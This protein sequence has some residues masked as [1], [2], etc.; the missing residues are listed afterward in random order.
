MSNQALL[1]AKNTGCQAPNIFIDFLK[2][3]G[4]Y[5][6][7]SDWVWSF[8]L[9]LSKTILWELFVYWHRGATLSQTMSQ[10][11]I[12]VEGLIGRLHSLTLGVLW[13]GTLEEATANCWQKPWAEEKK[14][15][16][17]TERKSGWASERKNEWALAARLWTEALCLV[18]RKEWI[19]GMFPKDKRR[20]WAKP[21]KPNT[22]PLLRKKLLSLLNCT[23]YVVYQTKL[24]GNALSGRGIIF[25]LVSFFPTD[26]KGLHLLALIRILFI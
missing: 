6:H 16:R 17:Q 11:V 1:Q 15:E 5:S 9:V 20:C 4:L 8:V 14:R 18:F 19:P 2:D 7:D 23:C 24:V 21:I 22:L 13:S 25:F 10:A 12:Y 3:Y 26:N